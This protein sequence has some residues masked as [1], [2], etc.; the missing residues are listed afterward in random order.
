MSCGFVQYVKEKKI[1]PICL[2]STPRGTYHKLFYFC[3]FRPDF[4]TQF[5]YKHLKTDYVQK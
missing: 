2:F 4:F 3:D 1:D 5:T